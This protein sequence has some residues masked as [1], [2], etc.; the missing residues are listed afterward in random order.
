MIKTAQL[1]STA[2]MKTD[3]IGFSS[4][5][6]ELSDFE[7][8][9]LLEEHKKFVIKIIYKH[10]GSIIK[11]EGDAFLISFS[12]VTSAVESGIEIQT[13][14]RKQRENSDDKFRLSLKIIISL[15]DVLHK[16][17][18]VYGES[19]NIIS[20]IEDI[21]PPD[22]VYIT[23]P[24]YLTVKKKK[25]NMEKVGSFEFKGFN[26]THN[27]FRVILG[28]KTIVLEDQFILFSDLQNFGSLVN[29]YKLLEKTID[30]SDIMFQHVIK[31]FN[32]NLRNVIADAYLVTF[33]KI[34]DLIN[35]LDHLNDHWS[36]A[37]EKFELP[38]MRLGCHKG[39]INIYRSCISGHAFNIAARLES[40]GKNLNE[41]KNTKN[42]VITHTSS[43][44]RDETLEYN[45]DLKKKFRRVS[46]KELLIEVN[47][48]TMNNFKKN[49][50]K[51]TY[52]YIA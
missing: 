40:I 31:R 25:I 52:S 20:R 50:K 10:D 2:I 9:Q 21:T 34:D 3:I 19:I 24:A 47:P 13:T 46:K 26:G 27:I 43:T 14:L 5:V 41:N 30:N 17:N 11:G 51:C 16:N 35:S 28:R 44:I 18:D 38:R 42:H 1:I 23:E 12:S 49:F 33:N 39:T 4:I 22:E 48:A 6:G 29:N 7:L 45:N 15:G 8:S 37:C 32:G 36:K